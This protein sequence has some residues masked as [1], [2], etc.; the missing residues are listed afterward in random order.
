MMDAHVRIPAMVTPELLTYIS[1]QLEHG[2]SAAELTRTL[3]TAGWAEADLAEA[4]HTVQGNTV[5]SAS[6]AG[7]GTVA[8]KHLAD[9]FS[10]TAVLSSWF[11]RVGFAGIFLA[12]ALVAW[13]TPGDFLMLIQDNVLVQLTGYPHVYIMVAGVNDLLLA[14]LILSG[15]WPR[16]VYVWA[17]FWLMVVTL[18]KLLHLL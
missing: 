17:S 8:S 18:V 16:V 6:A 9:V 13:F 1:Q 5:P 3:S 4:F 11:F 14:L 10:D 12:N 2:V 7:S 15:R